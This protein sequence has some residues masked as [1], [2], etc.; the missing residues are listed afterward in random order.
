MITTSA[1]HRLTR[2]LVALVIALAGAVGSSVVSASPASALCVSQPMAGNWHSTDP[3]TRSLTRVNVGFVCGDVRLCDTNGNCTGGE[4]YFT[5]RPF[6]KC[7]PTDCDWGTKRATTMSDGWQRA[8]YSY[9]WS[10][11]YVW[12]KTYVFSGVTY[13]RVY[14]FTDFTAADGRTDYTT[15]QWM[16][17]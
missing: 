5:V 17:K 10:T 13:L 3:N 12:L 2:L 6:G 7:S 16:L 4:S 1:P 11:K 8:T 14:T 9:S 15:D